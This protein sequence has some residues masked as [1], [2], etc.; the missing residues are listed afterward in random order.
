MRT[1]ILIYSVGML[2]GTALSCSS[3]PGTITPGAGTTGGNN[4]ITFKAD[5]KLVKTSGWNISRFD[6]GEG[7]GL[8]ITSNMHEDKRTLMINLRSTK[9][10]NYSLDENAT[11]DFSG[12]GDYKPDYSDLLNSF[13]FKKGSLRITSIDTTRGLLN[14]SFFGTVK[15]GDQLINITEGHIINGALNKTVHTY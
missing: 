3:R 11:E 7:P 10:G 8:N 4:L 14:A 9:P 13:H 12:Y 2:A 15:H 1:F 5:G 6:M